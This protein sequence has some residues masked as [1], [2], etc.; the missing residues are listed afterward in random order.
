MMFGYARN[1]LTL[2]PSICTLGYNRILEENTGKYSFEN[3]AWY[4]RLQSKIE[5]WQ[6][7]STS[8][9]SGGDV[10]DLVMASKIYKEAILIFLHTAFYGSKVDDP[11]SDS[12]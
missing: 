2:L 6:E 11:T 10:K 4:K 9:E 8:E 12:Y 3:I 1:L 5:S 7:L